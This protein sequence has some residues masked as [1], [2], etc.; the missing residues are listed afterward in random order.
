MT[1]GT[2]TAPDVFGAAESDFQTIATQEMRDREPRYLFYAGDEPGLPAPGGLQV[3]SPCIPR[4]TLWRCAVTPALSA[5]VRMRAVEIPEGRMID[6]TQ[7]RKGLASMLLPCGPEVDE[8]LATYGHSDRGQWQ[9]RWGLVELTALRGMQPKEVAALNLTAFFFPT[10]PTIPET[11]QAVLEHLQT[12]LS[13]ATTEI[14]RK[15][16]EEMIAAVQQAQEYQMRIVREGNIRVTFGETND[17]FKPG[18]DSKDELFAQRSGVGLAINALRGNQSDAA[19]A[20]IKEILKEVLPAVASPQ[21]D[22]N[23]IAAIVAATV[24][25]LNKGEAKP[26]PKD[27]APTAPALPKAPAIKSK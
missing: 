20:N 19:A 18:F 25:A 12:R 5:P 3:A 8:L 16:G 2:A 23:T 14:Q 1:T 21:I 6:G 9:K 17:R 27:E 26:E 4:Q 11:N 7:D 13:E 10:W 24:A 22:A 15:C